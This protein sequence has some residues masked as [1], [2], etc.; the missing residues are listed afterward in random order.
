M[1]TYNQYQ[2][3]LARQRMVEMRFVIMRQ[4]RTLVSAI[5]IPFGILGFAI[6]GF[7]SAWF[8]INWIEGAYKLADFNS[9]CVMVIF[10]AIGGLIAFIS[11]MCIRDPYAYN[12]I[13]PGSTNMFCT[14]CKNLLKAESKMFTC[15]HC[16][17]L[18]PIG[19]KIWV[20]RA[21]SSMITAFNILVV[22]VLLLVCF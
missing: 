1:L 21:W 7:Q 6:G 18:L 22:I 14:S 13:M 20:L 16:G 10:M 2:V 3:L 4:T 8:F 11:G 15:D 9:Y 17:K 5:L 12:T 19:F